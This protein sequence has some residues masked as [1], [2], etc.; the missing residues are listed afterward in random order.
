MNNALA[1]ELQRM[2]D[3]D[4]QLRRK[5]QAVHEELTSTDARNTQRLCEIVDE[6]GWPTR[7][8][9]GEAA[10]HLAWLLVQHAD[11]DVA[12]QRRCLALMESESADEVCP[13]HLAYL[14]DR[15]RIADGRPQRY[16]T[17]LTMTEHGLDAGPLEDPDKLDDR[18]QRVGLE[19]I[20]D[21]IRRA[22]GS[23]V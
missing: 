11:R 14:E 3:E 19:P 23:S 20:A 22:R 7:S 4:Q 2:A 6:M 9:V 10:E 17:Q 18:R 1:A 16:G 21:Y 13:K 8:R 15:I 5:M 12:F